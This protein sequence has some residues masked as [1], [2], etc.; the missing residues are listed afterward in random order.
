[1]KIK[2]FARL[3]PVYWSLIIFIL[4]QI[5]TFVVISRENTF[6]NNEQ[7]YIPSQ[8][9]EIVTLWPQTTTLPSGQ[10]SETPAYSSLGPILIYFFAVVIVLGIVLFLVPLSILK[11]ILK[12]LFGFLFGWGTF[13][14]LVMWLPLAAAIILAIAVGLAWFFYPKIW[15]HNMALV[16]ALS[17]VAAVFG[18]FLSPW[19]SMILLAALAVYDYLAVR[20]GYMIWM[21]KKMS[22][23]NTLP[24][25]II[26]R[27]ISDWNSSLKRPSVAKIAEQKPAERQFSILGG[28]DIGF[29]LLLM[30]SV[31]FSRGFTA[32]II[33]AAFTILGLLGAY[34]IQ[35]TIA[36]GKAVPALPPIAAVSL[37]GLVIITTLAI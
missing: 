14:I 2:G 21:A 33:I 9:S 19:T 13:I 16:L 32:A 17:A 7:I 36:K 18:R 28:G 6:L 31:Y 22:D 3:D 23:S 20:F 25:F 27:R 34:W 11:L 8:P 12:G 1:M 5:I 10:I 35:A 26:P 24:A 30:S 29:A 4:A 37:I 15:L